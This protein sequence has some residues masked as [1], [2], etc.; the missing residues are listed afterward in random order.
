M[1]NVRWESGMER[2]EEHPKGRWWLPW[3]ANFIGRRDFEVV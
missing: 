3:L 2:L 1:R